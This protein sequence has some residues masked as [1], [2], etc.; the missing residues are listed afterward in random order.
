MKLI[1]SLAVAATV[2]GI[3]VNAL[4]YCPGVSR[5]GDS[6]PVSD[7][8]I[9]EVLRAA[10]FPRMASLPLSQIIDRRW[11]H[12]VECLQRRPVSWALGQ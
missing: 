6:E 3:S 10:S 8:Q 2:I 1:Q 5:T 4:A 12:R 9:E 7:A 11:V